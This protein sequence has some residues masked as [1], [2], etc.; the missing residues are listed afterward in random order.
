VLLENVNFYVIEKFQFY[1]MI[2]HNLEK[3]VKTLSWLSP[4]T[5]LLAFLRSLN[6]TW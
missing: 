3:K 1:T 6:G 4:A 2:M 5:E